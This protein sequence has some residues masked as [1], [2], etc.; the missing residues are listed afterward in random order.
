MSEDNAVGER[1][2]RP[3]GGFRMGYKPGPGEPPLAVR[4]EIAR[5]RTHTARMRRMA[6]PMAGPMP[7]A[8]PYPPTFDWRAVN[9]SSFMTPVKAQGECD[10]CVAFAV[11]AAVEAM[12]HQARGTAVD[13][14]EAHLFYGYGGQEGLTC[15]SAWNPEAALRACRSGI[16]VEADFPYEAGN[17]NGRTVAPGWEAR[18]VKISDWKSIWDSE[19]MKYWLAMT[20]PVIGAMTVFDDL[21][22]HPGGIYRH[23][24][25]NRIGG[26]CVCVIGY[27]EPERYWI[28]KNSGGPQ[29]CEGGYFRIAYGECGIDAQMWAVKGI[30][31]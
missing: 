13:L 2:E 24:T 31:A 12:A 3:A 28:C 25:N 5:E 22:T 4:E 6:G 8:P 17:P 10:S 30:S 29:W 15:D 23:Q 7:A 9:G 19:E 14:S 1:V 18:A 11:I 20:G 27:N 16:A 21:P 26:H